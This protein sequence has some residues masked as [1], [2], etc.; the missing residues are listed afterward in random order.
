VVSL[1]VV[2]S[3]GCLSEHVVGECVAIIAG[4]SAVANGFVNRAAKDKLRPHFPHCPRYCDTDDRLTQST[5][6]AAQ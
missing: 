6:D 5:D 1:R 4:V 3:P 2:L